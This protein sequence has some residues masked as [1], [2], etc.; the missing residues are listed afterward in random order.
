MP[1]APLISTKFGR[2]MQTK[3]G[4]QPIRLSSQLMMKG[5]IAM[6]LNI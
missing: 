2:G 4:L 6:V 5:D 3:L 1:V